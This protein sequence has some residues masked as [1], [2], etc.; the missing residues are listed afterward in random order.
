MSGNLFIVSAPSGAG[1]TSLLR[2]L[3]PEDEQLKLSVS[4]TTRAPRDGEEDGVHYHFVS[5]E[6]FQQELK[7]GTFLESAE[8]FG[9][10][11]GTSEAAIREQLKAND[12]VFPL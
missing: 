10:F 2:R 7:A 12:P 11:Y 6:A 3:V 8:V 9:N 4:H 1:K 5:V